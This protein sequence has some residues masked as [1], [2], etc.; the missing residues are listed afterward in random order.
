MTSEFHHS[1]FSTP[2]VYTKDEERIIHIIRM[3]AYNGSYSYIPK[4]T[5]IAS[6]YVCG[7]NGEERCEYLPSSERLKNDLLDI[8]C[9]CNSAYKKIRVKLL[10]PK[11]DLIRVGIDYLEEHVVVYGKM[12]QKF[13]PHLKTIPFYLL[14]PPQY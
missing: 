1:G 6:R 13:F 8:L 2:G 10:E 3:G 7:E 12:R 11:S 9:S 14:S 4:W 5:E